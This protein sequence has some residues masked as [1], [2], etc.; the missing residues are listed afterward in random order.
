MNM[1]KSDTLK[2]IAEKLYNDLK[3][4]GIDVL[5]DDRKERAGIM[6]ADMELIGIPHRIVLGD[7]GLEK[8]MVEYKARSDKDNTDIALDDIVDF[9]KDKLK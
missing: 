8:G 5:F 1:H 3:E 4:L 9:I 7:R 2:P 6:F